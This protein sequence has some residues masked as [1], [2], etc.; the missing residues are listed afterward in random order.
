MTF[1]LLDGGTGQ[2]LHR[3]L[4]EPAT[5]LWSAEALIRRPDA[6]QAVH[7]DFLRAGADVITLA[8]YTATPLRLAEA[9]RAD[10]FDTLQAAAVE[11]A[12]RARDTVSPGAAIAGCLPPLHASYRP[13]DMPSDGETAAECA[14]I[15]EAQAGGVDLFLCETLSTISGAE[16]ATAAAKATGKPIWTA[17]TV[18]EQDPMRLRGGEPLME[19]ASAAHENGA[20]AVL[21]NCS[22][23]EHA[24]QGVKA[25]LAAGY[26]AGAYANGFTT[27]LPL[28]RKGATV[29]ALERREDLGPEAYADIALGWAEAGASIIGGCCEIEPAHIAEIAR[30][31]EASMRLRA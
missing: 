23:P 3:R 8:S 29:D 12:R 28:A 7:A 18:H 17:L 25:L 21:I 1:T 16:H 9:G 10:A 2:T 15:V 26:E 6:V 13:E 31:R 14:R 24:T 30:R 20:A 11:A 5:P 19:A 22:S 27:A 4:G